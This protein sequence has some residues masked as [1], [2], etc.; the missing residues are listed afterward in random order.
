MHRRGAIA[1]WLAALAVGA[2]AWPGVL[3]GA[4]EV[5][6]KL[7]VPQ[8]IDVTG[9]RRILVGGF[10][11]ND[12]PTLD[13]DVE[14]S[15]YLKGMLKRKSTFEVIDVDS[16]PLPEQELKDVVKNTSYWKRLGQ[17]FS[18]DLIVAGSLEFQRTDKSGFVSEDIISPVT[19][20][21]IRRTRYAEREEF[22]LVLNLYFF[23]GATGE[24]MYET[25]LSEEAMY[26]GRANDGLSALHQLA[27]RSSPEVM[28]VLMPRTKTET[29]Y[30]LVE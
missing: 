20:Q 24:L 19:G 16:P 26:E 28:G 25:R 15:K 18:A 11:A 21:R 8:K 27:E 23:R 10:R 3:A 29:R 4:V 13:I 5:Q 17:R 30:L 1:S 22:S 6:V 12:D 9:M 7:P 14:Y 2:C